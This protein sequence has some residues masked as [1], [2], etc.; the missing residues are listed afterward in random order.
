MTTQGPVRLPRVFSGIQPSGELHL[1]NY[2]GALVRWVELQDQYECIYS[3][4]DMH[5]LTVLPNPKELRASTRHVA[6]VCIACGVDPKK[7]TLFVQSQAPR[8]ADLAWIMLCLSSYGELGRMTQFKDK[9]GERAGD[10]VGAGLF[11]YPALMAADILLYNAKFVPVGADQKQHLELSRDLAGRFNSRYGNTFIVPEPLISESTGRIMGLDDPT[12]KMSKSSGNANSYIALR[13]APDV[14]RA[15]VRRAVTDSGTDV[16]SGDDKPALTNL[17]TIF[18]A[19]TG[20]TVQ[21]L[22]QEYGS[23][24]YAKFKGDLAESLVVK[25][26]PIQARL[27]ELEA[28]TTQLDAI[29]A[30][31]AAKAGEKSVFKMAEVRQKIGFD[32]RVREP[33]RPQPAAAKEKADD[34]AH[35]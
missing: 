13:D 16:R 18:S 9:A 27:A 29:L 17:L 5:A 14:I 3:V 30:E 25:L 21:A 6:A 7:A 12:K 32:D 2:L 22:E 34:P 1:G 28:D 20:R 15:K 35:R 8:H 24:G 23:G 11:T 19:V 4:V 10:P 33:K 26:S 31:G